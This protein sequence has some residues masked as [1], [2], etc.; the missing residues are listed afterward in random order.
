MPE[1]SHD[2][3]YQ[4]QGMRQR[5]EET[6]DKADFMPAAFAMAEQPLKPP[7]TLTQPA[8]MASTASITSGYNHYRADSCGLVFVRIM[9]AVLVLRAHRPCI[10]RGRS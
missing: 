8:Q 5:P 10:H 1:D 4:R 3:R 6:V 7:V 2:Q 9:A